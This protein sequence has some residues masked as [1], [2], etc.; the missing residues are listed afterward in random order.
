MKYQVTIKTA[1]NPDFTITVEA[2]NEWHARS[3]AML[4]YPHKLM[5]AFVDYDIAAS[6]GA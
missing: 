4:Q 5:G 3:V 2:R 1:K 6:H